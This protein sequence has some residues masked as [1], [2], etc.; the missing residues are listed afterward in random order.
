MTHDRKAEVGLERLIRRYVEQFRIAEN[1]E[2]Y[3]RKDYKKAQKRFVK[4]CLQEG[5]WLNQVGVE[6]EE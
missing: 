6:N 1:L 4:H 2:H 5:C 3:S